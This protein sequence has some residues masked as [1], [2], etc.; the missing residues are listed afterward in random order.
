[1]TPI[2]SL[3]TSCSASLHSI[4]ITVGF[5]EETY[6]VSEPTGVQTILSVCMTIKEGTLG[7]DLTLRP[8]ATDGTATSKH[9]RVNVLLTKPFD[10]QVEYQVP[11][12][13]TCFRRETMN[14]AL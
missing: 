14:S 12:E 13:T 6:I 7:R 2:Q 8:T 3:M 4:G 11:M 5:E 1:M 10:V 9:F